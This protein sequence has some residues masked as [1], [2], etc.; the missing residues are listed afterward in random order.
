MITV[1]SAYNAEK[2]NN[3]KKVALRDI[4]LNMWKYKESR[5]VADLEFILY[6]NVNEKNMKDMLPTVYQLMGR[7]MKDD[8]KNFAKFSLRPRASG[9]EQIAYHKLLTG[10]PFAAGASKML[11]EYS[12]FGTRQL[13]N[14][15]F[16]WTSQTTWSFI[17]YFHKS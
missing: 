11:R 10:T 7:N 5:N 16:Q 9:N 17:V 12:E 13:G 3:P 1:S 14:F 15:E 4:I 6:E 8:G 2:D